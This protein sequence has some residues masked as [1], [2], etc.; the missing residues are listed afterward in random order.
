MVRGDLLM[1]ALLLWMGL[2]ITQAWGL[3]E[4]ASTGTA[5]TPLCPNWRS[6]PLKVPGINGAKTI[7]F[8]GAISWP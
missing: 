1:A 3:P 7:A 5:A 4:H 8:Q 2:T 6:N